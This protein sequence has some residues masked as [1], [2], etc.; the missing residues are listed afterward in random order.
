MSDMFFGK[1]LK[2]L[3]LKHAEMGLRK[4]SDELGISASELSNIE[5]G[6]SPHPKEEYW[7]YKIMDILKMPQYSEDEIE[8]CRL[9]DEPFVMQFMDEDIF[10]VHGLMADGSSATPEKLG[11][12]SEWMQNKAKEHN[13]K[14]RKY[15][16]QKR[17]DGSDS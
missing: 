12:V 6:L 3:R 14:A 13:E 2:E 1:K 7:L 4:F 17:E 10:I 9:W 15:N 11:E 8:L 16:G 5:R